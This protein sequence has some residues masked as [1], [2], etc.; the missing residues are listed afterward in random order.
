MHPLGGSALRAG[1]HRLSSTVARTDG[2]SVRS[3]HGSDG[4]RLALFAL[5]AIAAVLVGNAMFGFGLFD[6]EGPEDVAAEDLELD[7]AGPP[8]GDDD[9]TSP[10]DDEAPEDD[11]TTADDAVDDGEEAADDEPG[12]NDHP[13]ADDGVD[14]DSAGDD[15]ADDSPG[16]PDDLDP[17]PP[18]DLDPGP[19]DD[20]SP[21]PSGDND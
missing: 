18:D 6:D 3:D 20:H 1:F 5:V 11:T 8:I 4:N 7:D 17:G 13:P 15:D 19:P 21:G 16:P 2:P 10:P 14:D 9:E 12:A